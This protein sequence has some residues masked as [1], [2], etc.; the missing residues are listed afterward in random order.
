MRKM[1][2]S[3]AC[4]LKSWRPTSGG[5]AVGDH[6]VLNDEAWIIPEDTAFD[7]CLNTFRP[8]TGVCRCGGQK[9]EAATIQSDMARFYRRGEND[10]HDCPRRHGR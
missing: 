1:G 2:F 5:K 9:V 4:T 10:Y 3:A 8:A 6:D 7:S